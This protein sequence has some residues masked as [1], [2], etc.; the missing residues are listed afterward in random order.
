VAALL[1]GLLLSATTAKA[2]CAPDP[3]TGGQT[4]TCS[5]NDADGFQ[6]GGGVNALTVNVLSGA[7][8][9]DNGTVAIGLNDS[10]TVTNNGTITAGA[11]GKGIF[12]GVNN[13]ITNAAT[14]VITV[15]DDSSGI[16]VAGNG[17]VTNA[18]AIAIGNVASPAAG[19]FAINDFNTLVNAATGTITGGDGAAGLAVQ[20]NNATVTNAG[21]ITLR[22][23]APG[24]VLQGDNA[25]ITNTGTIVSRDNSVGIAV[26]GD[27]NTIVNR[28]TITVRNGVFATGIDST[29]IF[30]SNTIINTE[31]VNVGNNAVGIFVSGDGTVFNSGKINAA[32]GSAAIEFCGCGVNST[33]TLGP[34]SAIQGLVIGTGSETFQLGG[35]GKDTFNLSSI[36]P[37]DS[38]TASRPSTRSTAPPGP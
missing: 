31:T 15:G 4:V 19:I 29:S 2:A 24:I 12:A 7:M 18:G 20:G 10:N 26:S 30:G 3:A 37:A 23:S 11:F 17:V 34:G 8:V 36:G 5:G 28:G 16:Y 1:A 33:L 27:S 22:D 35:T 13:T 9:N 21:I 6:A 25:V 32:S 14:G 38:T